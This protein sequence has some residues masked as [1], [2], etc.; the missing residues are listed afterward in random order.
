MKKNKRIFAL[1]AT[2]IAS[3]FIFTACKPHHNHKAGFMLDYITEV[4]DLNEI[5][6]EKLEEI[7]TDIMVQFEEMHDDKKA[8][9]DTLKDQLTAETIDK[10]VIKQLVSDHM[11]KMDNVIDMAIDRL[12]D[13]HA[14]LS[15]EQRQKLV[16]KLEKMDRRHCS[17][18]N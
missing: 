17:L 7:R 8:M 6:E 16:A 10:L 13:F 11:Q 18:S 9:H 12:S 3:L 1:A 2:L 5:Q 14:D 15:P 4:L